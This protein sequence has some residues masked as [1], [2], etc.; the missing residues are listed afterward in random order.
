MARC[1]AHRTHLVPGEGRQSRGGC[2]GLEAQA[3]ASTTLEDLVLLT[4]AADSAVEALAAVAGLSSEL[5]GLVASG[6]PETG[7]EGEQ[8]EGHGSDGS[9]DSTGR[10]G[11]KMG[12]RLRLR[13][14]L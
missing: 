12:S 5:L 1:R 9:D 7:D 2:R 3:E 10:L 8:A 13:L 6:V 4:S 11:S 14:R